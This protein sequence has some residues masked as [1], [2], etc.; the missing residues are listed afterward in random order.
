MVLLACLGLLMLGGLVWLIENTARPPLPVMT[1]TLVLVAGLVV[2]PWIVLVGRRIGTDPRPALVLRRSMIVAA[3]IGLAGLVLG[4]FVVRDNDNASV[5]IAISVIVSG[6]VALVGAVLVPWM[7]VLVRTVTRERAARVRAEE[8]AAVAAHLHDSVLQA[9]TLIQK[10]TAEPQV[11]RLARG[12]ERELRAWLYGPPRPV[13][14]AAPEG[15]LAAA[16]TAMAEE[17]EDLFA[18]R[19]ELITVG[20][21]PLSGPGEAMLGAVREALTNAAK[22]A[23]VPCVSALVEVGDAEVY[24]LV[25]DAGR[26][27]D[28]SVHSGRRGIADSIVGRLRR[29]GGSATIRSV[30]GSGTMVEMLMPAPGSGTK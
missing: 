28:P 26:G 16:A 7:F 24:A 21:C 9:L 23:G 10:Q 29:H 11:L 3:G 2:V 15:D 27:F 6:A 20:T 18:V 25:R 19:V 30:T 4:G 8:R 5:V 1:G 13:G 17:I 12:T 14:S 22:H